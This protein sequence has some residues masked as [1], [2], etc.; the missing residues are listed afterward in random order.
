EH[1]RVVFSTGGL[2]EGGQPTDQETPNTQYATFQYAD[3]VAL[4]CDV[5]GWYTEESDSG[6]Y[7]YGSDGWM[8]IADG[9]V[10][11]YVGRKNEPGPKIGST[12]EDGN[13]GGS[14][15]ARRDRHMENFIDCI[16]SRKWQDLNAEILEGHMSTSL[17]H[18]G[19]ISHRVRRSVVFDSTTERFVD[20]AEADKLLSRVYRPPFAV[21]STV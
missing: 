13:G 11:V 14:A 5:R 3:G 8:R 21:P 4:H 18:L 1:P 12:D 17:C 10:D 19:N 7:I 6:L 20:D 2:Y 9:K 15:P 16:R